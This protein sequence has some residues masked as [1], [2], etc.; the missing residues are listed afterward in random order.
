VRPTVR[1]VQYRLWKVMPPWSRRLAVRLFV[2]RVSLGVCAVIRDGYGRVLIAH[3]PYRSAWGLPG[4]FVN[5]DEQ[6]AAALMREIREEL[7]V[8]ASVGPLLAA[9][10]APGDGHLTLY[11]A[12][13]IADEPHPNSVEIDAL[14]HVPEEALHTLLDPTALVWLPTMHHADAA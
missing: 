6:P 4:G 13:S 11:Y 8:E 1:D 9:H 3:H 7:G 5:S 14:R 12:T 2:P 10:A